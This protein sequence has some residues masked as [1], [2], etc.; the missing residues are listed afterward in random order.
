MT[1]PLVNAA[2]PTVSLETNRAA[3]IPA[4]LLSKT[5]VARRISLSPW[6][7]SDLHSGTPG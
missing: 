7:T 2:P 1:A 5:A 3:V 6:A 4:L